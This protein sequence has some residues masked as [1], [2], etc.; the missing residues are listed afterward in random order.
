MRLVALYALYLPSKLLRRVKT[1]TRALLTLLSRA[2]THLSKFAQI[3]VMTGRIVL[4]IAVMMTSQRMMTRMT[5]TNKPF[6]TKENAWNIMDLAGYVKSSLPDNHLN[7]EAVSE[8]DLV[9]FIQSLESVAFT[10]NRIAKEL[11][12][13]LQAPKG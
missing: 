12:D 2:Q 9:W 10:A 5:M 11:R 1:Q 8:T 6:M 4:V 3:A 7:H 13:G